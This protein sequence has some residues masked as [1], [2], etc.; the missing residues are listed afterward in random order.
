MMEFWLAWSCAGLMQT[1][2]WVW[3]WVQTCAGLIQIITDINQGECSNC[4]TWKIAFHGMPLFP[5]GLLSAPSCTVCLHTGGAVADV[6]FMAKHSMIAYSHPLT[7]YLSG[8]Y[9][10][11]LKTEASVTTGSLLWFCRENQ[12]I[13]GSPQVLH[14]NLTFT[15]PQS[16]WCII[17]IRYTIEIPL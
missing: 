12:I 5:L 8:T 9:C 11:S 2:K 13:S 15:G 14:Q 3:W 17:S 16:L 6:P 10:R 7:S 1:L 4:C